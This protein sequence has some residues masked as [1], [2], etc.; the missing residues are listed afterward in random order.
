MSLSFTKVVQ[1]TVYTNFQTPEQNKV[2]GADVGNTIWRSNSIIYK[3][4][5][6][7]PLIIQ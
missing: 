6:L 2:N 5:L 3:N 7:Y 1:F 4:Y